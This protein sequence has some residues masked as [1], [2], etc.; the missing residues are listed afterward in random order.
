MICK[1][2]YDVVKESADFGFE[3]MFWNYFGDYSKG[4]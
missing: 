4:I 3:E 2:I 1:T